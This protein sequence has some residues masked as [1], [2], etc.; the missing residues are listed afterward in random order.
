MTIPDPLV[1]ALIAALVSLV[2]TLITIQQSRQSRAAAT[3]SEIG[4]LYDQLVSYRQGH[5]EVLALS[6]TWQSSCIRLVYE[7]RSDEDRAWAVYYGYAELCL[8]YANEVLLGHRFGLLDSQSFELHHKHLVKLLLTEHLPIVSQLACDEAKFVSPVIREFMS[9]MQADEGWDWQREYESLPV[10]P[11]E[12]EAEHAP[13][14]DA[15]SQGAP[16]SPPST[17]RS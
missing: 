15:A 16:T 14:A 8:G 13:A 5:P 3:R 4:N 2:V 1:A 11:E 10:P 6:R 9:K 12:Q 7:Q 17:Q